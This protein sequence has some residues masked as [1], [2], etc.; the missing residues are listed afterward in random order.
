M[1]EKKLRTRDEIPAQY[2]WNLA[3]M[4]ASDE[5]WEKEAQ[6]VL[7]LSKELEAYK[8]RLAENAATLLGNFK[9]NEMS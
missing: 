4:F 3:D 9:K 8:G 1:G 6:L 5:L 2:K 7:E